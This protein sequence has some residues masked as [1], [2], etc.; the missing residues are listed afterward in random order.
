[1]PS[2]VLTDEG[3]D[4]A[5]DDGDEEGDADGDEDDV[6]DLLQ[7]AVFVGVVQEFLRFVSLHAI[8]L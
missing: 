5:D 1:M 3:V 2:L 7:D 6:E 4:D 8:V